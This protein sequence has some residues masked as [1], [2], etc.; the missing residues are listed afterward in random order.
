MRGKREENGRLEIPPRVKVYWQ[1]KISDPAFGALPF[2]VGRVKRA[3]DAAKIVK[4]L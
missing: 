3:L 2:G 4:I 1:L